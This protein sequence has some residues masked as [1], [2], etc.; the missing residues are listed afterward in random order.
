MFDVPMDTSVV[1][2]TTD[3]VATV[4]GA[5]RN[6]ASVEW[7]DNQTFGVNLVAPDP[8]V[9]VVVSLTASVANY[10]SARGFIVGNYDLDCFNFRPE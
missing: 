5:P 7:R 3:F 8:T 1:P 10:R 4:D 9:S 6:V 2:L